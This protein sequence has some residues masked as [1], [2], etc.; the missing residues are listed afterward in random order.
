MTFD[1]RS[2]NPQHPNA[3]QWAKYAFPSMII[4]ATYGVLQCM[5]GRLIILT[6]CG[7]E[8]VNKGSDILCELSCYYFKIKNEL[9]YEYFLGYL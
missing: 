5:E 9:E 1:P 3:G 4:S 8:R 2:D 6:T 7:E